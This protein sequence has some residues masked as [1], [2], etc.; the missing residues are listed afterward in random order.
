MKYISTIF[1]AL[2]ILLAS[3]SHLPEDVKLI[4]LGTEE[5]E[6]YLQAEGGQYAMRIYVDGEFTATVTEGADWLSFP[7]GDTFTAGSDCEVL[8]TYTSNK[9]IERT[10]KVTLTRETK[11]S[12]VSFTQ[13]GLFDV[14]LKFMEHNVLC[15]SIGAENSAKFLTVLTMDEI[16]FDV[17]YE[18]EDKDWIMDLTKKNNFLTF[19][20]TDNAGSIRR[21][22]ITA[23]SLSEPD[24][25]DAVRVSQAGAGD[26]VTISHSELKAMLSKAGSVTIE[27]DYVLEGIVINDNIQG[28]GAPNANSS[29]SVQDLTLADRTLYIQSQDERSGV[30]LILNTKEDNNTERFDKIRIH[31]NGLTLTRKDSPTR[32]TLTNASGSSILS[33]VAGSAY[34]ARPGESSISSLTDDMLYTLVT[35][36]GCEI[37]FR[38]GPFVPI[39]LRHRTVIN[40]YPMLVRDHIGASMHIMTNLGASWERDGKG[41]PQ[42]AGNISGVLVYETCDN[43]EWNT[44]EAA[45][46][47]AQ[48]VNIDYI[49]DI[50][51]ISRYQIRP[52]VKEDIDIPA[53]FEDGFSEMI[54]EVRYMNSSHPETVINTAENVIHP[55]YP[56]SADPLNDSSLKGTLRVVGPATGIGEWRDWTHLGPYENGIITEKDNGNGVTDYNGNTCH[57]YVYSLVPSTGLIYMDNGSAWYASGWGPKKYWLATFPTTGLTPANFPISVQF[58]A[59][60]GQ[61]EGVGAPRYWAVEYSVDGGT[62]WKTAA[63]YTV[64]DFSILYKK[65]LWQCPGFKMMSFNLP[66]DPDL[67]GKEDVMVRLRPTSDIAGTMDSYDGGKVSPS[68]TSALNYFAIRYNK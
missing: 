67:L 6:V 1:P 57:W 9:S 48:G 10:A 17:E 60:S 53:D 42:G 54:M 25:R 33:T 29:G 64:P 5:T 28:N 16:G 44:A 14:S 51:H 37:P 34:D 35:V 59:E 23:Y 50:G 24:L 38:K 36:T 18:G 22:T 65:R 47:M 41:M 20:T 8:L 15:G 55:T 61:G 21:A 12:V 62:E 3:C 52:I 49:N 45:A 19:T 66:E 58:G 43:F 56:L 11:T 13:E 40:R 39:D 27:K 2:L 26:L 63:E 31:L 7:D 46:K 68:G 32:Y 30:C 4:E